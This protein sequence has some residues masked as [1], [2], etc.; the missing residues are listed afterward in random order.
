[1]TKSR[2]KAYWLAPTLERFDTLPSLWHN[3][4]PFNESA[5]RSHGW[6]KCYE[7]VEDEPASRTCTKYELIACLNE[8]YPSL[9]ASL[10]EAYGNDPDLQF[11][12]NT[13]I[14]LDRDNDDFKAAV[15]KLGVTEEQLD[16]IF[17]KI[18]QI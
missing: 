16:D 5:A 7:R 12:W 9:L 2:S 3:I 15:S 11:Y 14:Q 8:H 17:S 4:S 13:V 10:K 6:V 1:M 18:V